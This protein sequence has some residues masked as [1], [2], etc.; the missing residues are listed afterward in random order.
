MDVAGFGR[1]PKRDPEVRHTDPQEDATMSKYTVV[2]ADALRAR[3]F[4]L[5]D[6]MTPEVESSPRLMER[7]CLVNPEKAKTSAQRR[8]KSNNGRVFE[9]HRERHALEGQRHFTGLIIKEA[10]KQTRKV[11]SHTLVLVAGRKTLGLIRETLSSIKTNG[12]AIHE[13]DRDLTS[14]TPQKI[15]EILAKRKLV[16]AMKKPARQ[17]RK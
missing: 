13:W 9:D 7:E 4:S 11:D 6:S 16:P 5:Q 12:L 2:V 17:A 10:L 3:F 1:V 14:E 8:E 15:Q